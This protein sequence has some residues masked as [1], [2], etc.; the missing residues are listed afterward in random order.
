MSSLTKRYCTF[1]LGAVLAVPL[2]AAAEAVAVSS[3]A[4]GVA[5]PNS[6]LLVQ[7][8]LDFPPYQGPPLPYQLSLGAVFDPD[9]GGG[10][11]DK[12]NRVEV[13]QTNVSVSFTIG[14]KNFAYSGPGWASAATSDAQWYVQRVGFSY[15]SDELAFTATLNDPGGFRAHPL[16][17]I[18]FGVDG[19][20]YDGVRIDAYPRNPDAPGFWTLN[21][22]AGQMTLYVTSAVPEP[23]SSWMAMAGLL[24]LLVPLRR[25][26]AR[27]RGAGQPR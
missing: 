21:A 17:P 11:T 6:L 24:A 9:A 8:G 20:P 15:G 18:S 27:M 12:N 7:L 10:Y 25:Q 2:S 5:D 22:D 19:S 23:A 16:T 13:R 4:T 1:L 3:R 14:G 26:V